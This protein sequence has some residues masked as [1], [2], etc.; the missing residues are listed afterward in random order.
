MS[1]AMTQAVT[2]VIEALDA[3][4]RAIL[5]GD[6]EE[7]ER[8]TAEVQARTEAVPPRQSLDLEGQPRLK[9]QVLE[10]AERLHRAAYR[11]AKLLLNARRT[12]KELLDVVRTNGLGIAREA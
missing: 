8:W 9:A 10:L 6:V 2:Q 3:Q 7:L 11:N 5:R 4:E 1:N 12:T